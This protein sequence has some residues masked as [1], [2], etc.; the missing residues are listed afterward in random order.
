M[1]VYKSVPIV[2]KQLFFF[3][4]TLSTNLCILVEKNFIRLTFFFAMNIIKWV[5]KIP[6]YHIDSQNPE[7]P[8]KHR[9]KPF[10]K[11]KNLI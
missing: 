11:C 9:A 5:K 8:S 7:H 4:L 10:R 2:T 1:N 6:E 3:W